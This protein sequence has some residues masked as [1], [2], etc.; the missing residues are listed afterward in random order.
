VVENGSPVECPAHPAKVIEVA[1]KNGQNVKDY[2]R[3]VTS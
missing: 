2:R 3:E 1:T